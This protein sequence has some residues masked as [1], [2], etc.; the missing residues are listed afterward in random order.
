[1][2]AA[3]WPYTREVCAQ[4]GRQLYSL[5]PEALPAQLSEMETLVRL[6]QR[7]CLLLPVALYI[8][9]DDWDSSP[10]EIANTLGV[11]LSRNVGLVFLGVRETPLRIRSANFSVDVGLPTAREQCEAWTNTLEDLAPELEG[12]R[13]AEELADQFKLNLRDILGA[14]NS[15][16]ATD[17]HQE[18]IES[19]LWRTCRELMRPRMDSL[20]QRLEPKATWDDLVLPPEQIALLHQIAGQVRERHKVY[21]HGASQ[22]DESRVRNHRAVCG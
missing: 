10:N 21:D 22:K 3:V 13:I 2:R 4:A 11:F 16:L 19:K 9:A 18:S 1:M 8:E 20:A 14:A 5:A 15:A 12:S 17:N 6:W 7:E